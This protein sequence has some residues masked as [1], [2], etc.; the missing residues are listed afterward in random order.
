MKQIKAS[1]KYGS[2]VTGSAYPWLNGKLVVEPYSLTTL[3][4][5]FHRT[6]SDSTLWTITS[7]EVETFPLKEYFLRSNFLFLRSIIF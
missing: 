2:A 6:D 3:T 7:K 5:D 4:A 1:N